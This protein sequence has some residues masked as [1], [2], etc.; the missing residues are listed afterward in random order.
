MAERCV[1][2]PTSPPPLPS[3][4]HLLLL[5]APPVSS[6]SNLERHGDL[7]VV[8]EREQDVALHAEALAD[9]EVVEE[10]AL[11]QLHRQ[12]HQRHVRVVEAVQHI[13]LAKVQL[14]ELEMNGEKRM[15]VSG[16]CGGAQLNRAPA[17]MSSGH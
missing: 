4:P 12:V 9:A 11:L 17:G 2:P 7:C 16:L 8:V 6:G 10:G 1:S 3:Y 5:T 15:Y 14:L 13:R